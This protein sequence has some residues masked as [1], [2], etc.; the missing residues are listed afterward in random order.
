MAHAAGG[1]ILSGDGPGS[2]KMEVAGT[3]PRRQGVMAASG[4]SGRLLS[5]QSPPAVEGVSAKNLLR[6]SNKSGE[7]ALSVFSFKK[8]LRE[9]IKSSGLSAQFL[10]RSFN[11]GA[12]GGERKKMEIASLLTLG[13]KLAFLDEIDSGLDIDALKAVSAGVNNFLDQGDTGVILVSHSSGILK[14][15]SPTHVHVF[16]GGRIIKSGG[17]EI[18]E[19]I[20]ENGY[21]EFID[22]KDCMSQDS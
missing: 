3:H 14:H 22:C 17:M 4:G 8:K 16:C 2:R 10:T 6:A 5:H 13:A 11:D 1:V 9:S 15:L 19:K 18:A 12:S 20:H 7:N 21:A